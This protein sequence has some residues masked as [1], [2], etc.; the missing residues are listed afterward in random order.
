MLF[1]F[2]VFENRPSFTP[3]S[4]AHSV[5]IS[6]LIFYQYSYDV[7]NMTSNQRSAKSTSS[8]DLEQSFFRAWAKQPHEQE[9]SS[10]TPSPVTSPVSPRTVFSYRKLKRPSNAREASETS[11]LSYDRQDVLTP[12]VILEELLD[13]KIYR[14]SD[15]GLSKDRRSST[16]SERARRLLRFPTSR[17]SSSV[18]LEDSPPRN[19]REGHIWKRK[20]SGRWL[21][22]RIGHRTQSEV[23]T[24][25]YEEAMPDFVNET[26]SPDSPKSIGAIE[27][28]DFA[29]LSP[30]KIVKGP[31]VLE[32]AR[33][34]SFYDRTKRCLHFKANS[35]ELGMNPGSSEDK[36]DKNQTNSFTLEILRRASTILR[37]LAAV[38][39]TT[40]SPSTSESSRSI[41]VPRSRGSRFELF[42]R[43]RDHSSSSSIRNLK[44]GRP[45]QVSPDPEALYTGSDNK[46][47]FRVELSAPGAPTYLPSEARRVNTP[48]LPGSDR[49]HRSFF[50]DHNTPPN[51]SSSDSLSIA[52][53]P[54]RKHLTGVTDY[55]RM[56]QEAQQ[57]NKYHDRFE[58]N[59]PDHLPSS[60]LCPR[61]P[62]YRSGGKGI[63]AHH[64]RNNST[65]LEDPDDGLQKLR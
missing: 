8:T 54:Q 48:P 11:Q 37:D 7:L 9:Y 29:P 39:K 46:Q 2:N 23:L 3:P 49:A 6:A 63:C 16:I 24:S 65:P 58:L 60:P 18:A 30:A 45:P 26:M 12:N 61:N 50:F 53:T 56:K 25:T 13:P 15:A 31:A 55:Y 34:V 5:Y 21:E 52:M 14:P 33:R 10:D 36:H 62:K 41:A 28:K 51:Q 17:R 42:H 57:L 27:R 59:I 1:S 20:V 40:P 38:K 32:S 64:G 35:D 47:Y 19:A 22:I 43:S 4:Y 44:M